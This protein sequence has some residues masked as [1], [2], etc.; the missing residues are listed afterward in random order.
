MFSSCAVNN[1]VVCERK[2]TADPQK[3]TANACFVQKTDGAIVSY[4]SLK[5]VNSVFNDSY[6]LAD[7]KIKIYPKDIRSYQTPEYFA[8][9]QDIFANGRKSHVSVECLPGFATRIAKG[10]LNIYCKKIYNGTHAV[11]EFFLQQG[12]E[13][14]IVAYSPKLMNELL[15]DNNEA[16]NYFN[17]RNKKTSLNKKLQ[18]TAAMVNNGDKMLSKF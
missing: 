9:S 2:C 12:D 18:A 13:A 8:V 3:E 17:S 4:G 5:L 6:L 16:N 15:K 14:Q 11:D 1:A 10:K 7:G